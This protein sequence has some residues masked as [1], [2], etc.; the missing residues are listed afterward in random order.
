MD[1][2]SETDIRTW[3]SS[4]PSIN[5]PKSMIYSYGS[6]LE[7]RSR[8]RVPPKTGEVIIKG[9]IKL[10]GI[11]VV[12]LL[13]ALLLS[14]CAYRKSM[15][16]LAI[17]GILI[18]PMTGF[19]PW[20]ESE[21]LI[22]EEHTLVYADLTW[23]DWEP[24]PG[25]YDYKS[26]EEATH[27]VR[28]RKE[29]KRVV[30]RFV[31]DKPGDEKH[32]D[33]P[34]WLYDETNG[35]GDWYDTEYGKGYAPDY[36]DPVFLKR[37]QMAIK[38]L[39][40]RYGGDDFICFIEL[41]SLGHWGEW[42]VKYDSGIREIPGASV[43]EEYVHH[44]QDAF[45]NTH[46]MM[47]RPFKIAALDGLGLYNDMTGHKEDTEEW[48][49][50]IDNGGDYWQASEKG[51]LLPMPE[52]WKTAPIGGEFTNSIPMKT[53]LEDEL[54]TTLSLIR[55]S[56]TTFVG[57][58][59]PVNEKNGS[60]YVEGINKIGLTMGY[61]LRIEE[62][63]ISL[64]L[65]FKENS[66]ITLKWVNDGIAPL[67]YNWDTILYLLDIKG[68]PVEKQKVQVDLT[69]IIPSESVISRTSIDIKGTNIKKG[70]YQVALAIIDPLTG[71]PGIA[72]AMENVRKDRIY[73]IG[74]V[75]LK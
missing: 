74:T 42:H 4:V 16:P 63:V 20:A 37:H 66:E 48:L 32:M 29:G 25:F 57:P 5:N 75:E 24:E 35:N 69:S 7:V 21:R 53:M 9:M 47:R 41:G 3:S 72:L 36:A 12:M 2:P 26:F 10:I 65:L 56:H 54:D 15:S 64:P 19:A 58:H 39:G 70:V 28:W 55:R 40:E 52:G 49:D 61:R 23:R 34:D 60:M 43:R 18:N 44:Y 31:C 71:E 45:P 67:Y 46:L 1:R 50:W 14:S 51:A 62:A 59:V 73:V 38:A 33:I 27:L 13:M 6:R 68:N 22:T 30:F 8:R 17:E 11:I